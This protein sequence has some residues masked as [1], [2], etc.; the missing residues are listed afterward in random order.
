MAFGVGWCGETK[1]LPISEGGSVMNTLKSKLIAFS[2]LLLMLL[3]GC[4]PI[5]NKNA[6]MTFIYMATAFFAL[7]LLV[8]YFFSIEKKEKWFYVLFASVLVVNIGYLMLSMSDT[9]D[10][11]LWANRIAYLGSVFL[12][13]SMFKTIQK[14]SKLKYHKWLSGFLITVSVI[15]FFIAAS[16][17]W[18]DIYYKSVTLETVGGVSVL[19]KEYG[20]WHSVYLFYLFGYFTIM[21]ATTIHAIVKKKIESTSH[22][23]IIL[24]AVFVN[25]LVW[26]LE[27]LVKIDFEFLSISYIITELFLISV[28]HM[29]QNQEKLIAALKAQTIRHLRQQVSI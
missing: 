19:N 3:S 29:I 4:S 20:P 7:L 6:S 28:Y 18:L 22:A 17:G 2:F 25:I 13:L 27:Q 24:V 5:G 16:P 21:I 1:R 9:L 8:G 23:I 14:I 12:P 15:V 11:A 26:L 10:M